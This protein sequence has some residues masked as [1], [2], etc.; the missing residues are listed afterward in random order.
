MTPTQFCAAAVCGSIIVI[1]SSG[2]G[3][4]LAQNAEDETLPEFTE[5]FLA[6]AQNITAGAEIWQAQCRHCHGNSA[7]PGKAPK[8]K[9]RRYK[10]EFVYI[11]VTNGFGKMPAWKAVY[12]RDQ[13]MDVVAYILSSEFSP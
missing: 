4:A 6:D 3:G 13:R 9:P 12:N 7:Y 10:P 5:E 1:T 2:I 11:R 8:L